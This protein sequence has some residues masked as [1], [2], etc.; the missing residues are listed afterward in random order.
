MN[1]CDLID[2]PVHLAQKDAALEWLEGNF[3]SLELLNVENSPDS[4]GGGS[5]D[6]DFVLHAALPWAGADSL[7]QNPH[8][9]IFGAIPPE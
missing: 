3:P 5:L 6:L 4:A 2:G 8:P 1:L 9:L 7:S